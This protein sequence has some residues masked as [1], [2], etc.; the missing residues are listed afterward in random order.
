MV[1][2]K[3]C[4]TVGPS[5]AFIFNLRAQWFDILSCKIE[6]SQPWRQSIEQGLQ[7]QP[8]PGAIGLTKQFLVS[9]SIG[10]GDRMH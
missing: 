4:L 10:Q 7:R 3:I 1:N 8:D 6:G 2:I 9:R 5:Q